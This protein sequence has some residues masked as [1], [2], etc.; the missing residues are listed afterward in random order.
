VDHEIAALGV[1][2]RV[3]R[4]PFAPPVEQYLRG[5][6]LYVLPSRWESLP[7]AVLE[8]MACGLPVLATTV[9]GTGEAVRDGVTGR[10][11][12]PGDGAGL[13]AALRELMEDASGM[14]EAGARAAATEFSLD[15][16]I[17]DV[18]ALYSE[19]LR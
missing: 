12:P 17:D 5:F 19:L 3:L 14:G 9:G 11:V 18:A 13:A 4:L 6:D 1:Q 7:I 2:D 16:M 8:A 15:R 10:L